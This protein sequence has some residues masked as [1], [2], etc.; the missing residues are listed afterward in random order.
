MMMVMMMM[1]GKIMMLTG[2]QQG[3]VEGYREYNDHQVVLAGQEEIQITLLHIPV[4]S[5]SR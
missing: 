5:K 2:D 3:D 4:Q 1:M